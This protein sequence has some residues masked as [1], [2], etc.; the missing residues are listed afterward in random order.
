MVPD[1]Y[2][3]IVAFQTMEEFAQQRHA[4]RTNAALTSRGEADER[5]LASAHRHAPSR[6]AAFGTPLRTA[7]TWL[8][9]RALVLRGERPVSPAP[10]LGPD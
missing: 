10:A 8:Q 4:H 6:F 2:A 7:I 5:R 1:V 3:M 9:G